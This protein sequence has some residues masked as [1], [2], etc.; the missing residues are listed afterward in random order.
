MSKK[1]HIIPIYI[2]FILITVLIIVLFPREGEFRY[3]FTEGKPWKYGL[4]TA[5][6]DFPIYKTD[7]E[8]RK[9]RE[10]V[11]DSFSPYF[12]L[13]DSVK[14]NRLKQL[15]TDYKGNLH[16]NWNYT[17]Y[18]YVRKTLQQIYNNGV[19]S[20]EDYSLLEEGSSPTF[21]VMENQI[22]VQYQK[23][24]VYTFQTAYAYIMDNSPPHL[25]SEDL[26]SLSLG[27]YLEE[28]LRYDEKLSEKVKTD[29]LEGISPS[30]GMVQAGQK[31][32]DRGEIV[33]KE[34]FSILNSLK[35]VINSGKGVGKTQTWSFIG[36][37]VLITT[38]MACFLLYL[39]FFRKHIYYQRK[40]VIFLLS[41]LGLFVVLTEITVKYN[42]FNIYII[43]YAI[44]PISICTFFDSRTARTVHNVT[45]F[46]CSLMMPFPFE[47]IL[48]QFVTSMVVIFSLKDLTNRFQLIRCSLL[49]LITYIVIYLGLS[50]YQEGDWSMINWTVFIYFGINFIFLMFT[51]LLI[52]IIERIFGYTS[53]VSL[54]EL[55]DIN[56]PLLRSFSETAPGSF[57]HSLQV[58]IL[59]SAAASAIGANSLLVRTGA[60]YHD[61]GKMKAPH[62]FTEN[63]S[64]DNPHEKLT[65]EQ[66]AQ[67]IINH[68]IEGIKIAEKNNLPSIIVDFI[69]THHGKG[70]VK[71]F[72]NSFRNQYP[73]QEI[74]ES[75]FTYPGPNPFSKETG[76]LMMA[77][78]VEASSRSLSTYTEESIKEKVN[79]I[80]DGQVKDGLLRNTPLTFQDIETVKTVFIDKLLRIYHSRISYPELKVQEE[81][82]DTAS[83]EESLEGH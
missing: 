76:I 49:V 18:Q 39:Y 28:N 36:V 64:G 71:Y 7:Q 45:I 32:I 53:S 60:L 74:D 34:T 24:S 73:D 41:L 37:I 67:V 81:T 54:V 16:E 79:Q 56:S 35:I 23:T 68:V 22:A 27:K 78:A 6:F 46:I 10:K 29:L 33:N 43:P 69:R 59:G 3:L 62:Y 82:S 19:V 66:S 47:F 26:R 17:V 55:S 30:S 1:R 11:L 63:Q 57:Q 50:I 31:I 75:K 61:V 14:T 21:M 83:V 8:L 4:V 38:L 15:E 48:L 40:D 5:P 9:E 65:F 70:L 80:I 72:Y 25:D 44:I 13:I 52:Y 77:D 58:S 20:S 2:Y 42:L 12:N 51:Y